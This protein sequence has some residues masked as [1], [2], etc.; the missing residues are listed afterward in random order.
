VTW[1]Q[2]PLDVI[3]NTFCAVGAARPRRLPAQHRRR[4][5][6]GLRRA[7]GVLHPQPSTPCADKA[8]GFQIVDDLTRSRWYPTTALLARRARDHRR[9]LQPRAWASTP[10]A[11][12]CPT[13]STIPSAA[14]HRRRRWCTSSPTRCPTTSTPSCT[15]CPRAGSSSSRASKWTLWDTRR[16]RRAARDVPASRCQGRPG[17]LRCASGATP[18][19]APAPCSRLRPPT[20]TR[21][22][23]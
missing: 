19:P 5:V 12:T 14:R 4:L 22:R 10:P 9:R 3:T 6:P 17:Q 1:K 2:R 15:C 16:Q 21:R 18:W 23:S 11:P 20:G 7:R 13:S 8:C